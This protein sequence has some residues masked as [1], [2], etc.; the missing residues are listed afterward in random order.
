MSARADIFARLR[1]SLDAGGS[2]DARR[3]AVAARIAAPPRTAAPG[4]VQ[5]D[6][7]VGTFVQ[8]AEDIGAGVARV[9]SMTDVGAAIADVL[10]ARNLPQVAKISPELGDLDMAWPLT[11]RVTA[12]GAD[13]DDPVGVALA[14]AGVAETGTVILASGAKSPTKLNYLPETH[15]VVLPASRIVRTYEEGLDRVRGADKAALLPRT[16]NWITGPSR[17]ADIEQTILVG[18]HGP[19]RIHI[20]IV[21]HL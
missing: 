13:G 16:V 5:N 12:G 14:Q 21:E 11:M 17:T 9:A 18:V 4:R 20:V 8:R 19:K 6:D 10:R 3:A 15:I 2:P 1:S 7:P